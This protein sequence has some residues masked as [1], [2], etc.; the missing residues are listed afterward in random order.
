M[1]TFK[2]R[3][4]LL[5]LLGE[6]LIGSQHLA[7][8]ELVKNAYDADADQVTVT[9]NNPLDVKTAT[10]SILDNG[11]GMSLQ[12]I[13]NEWLELGTDSKEKAVKD[14][15]LTKKYKRLPLG[16]KGVGRFAAYKLGDTLTVHTKTIEEGEYKLTISL[17]EALKNKYI[18]DVHVAVEK[19]NENNEQIKTET[20][21]MVIIS[22]LLKPLDRRTVNTLHRE[23]LSIMSPF[24]YSENKNKKVNN[25]FK[26]NLLCEE[27]EEDI[28]DV[29][30]KDI[31]ESSMYRFKFIFENG[32]LQYK[33]KFAP[34]SQLQKETNIATRSIEESEQILKL[35]LKA[36]PVKEANYYENL[37]RIEGIFYVYDFDLNV[38]Q[39]YNNKQT[40]KEYTKINSGVRV[41]RGGVR[42]Y[43][44]GVIGNDWLE[45]DQERIDNPS[46]FISNRLIM[47]GIE[48]EPTTTKI[49]REKTNREGFI[50]DEEYLKFKETVRAILAVFNEQRS[51]DKEHL[52]LATDKKYKETIIDIDKPI[53][54][55]KKAISKEKL[56]K[57]IEKEINKVEKSYNQMR[58]VMLKSGLTGLNTAVTVHEIEKTLRRLKYA[59]S[60]G[61]KDLIKIE[62]NMALR[63]IDGISDLFKKDPVKRYKVSDIIKNILTL[64]ED[65]FKRHNIDFSCSLLTK[66][67]NDIEL[68][69]PKRMV[70][71]SLM[72]LIDNSIYWLSVRWYEEKDLIQKK[73]HIR[74][75]SINGYPAILILD[76][77]CRF[78]KGDWSELFRPFVTTKPMGVGMGLGLYYVKTAMDSI[79]GEIL[80]CNSD[81]YAAGK[82]MNLTG[83][84]VALIFKEN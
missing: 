22:N 68:N 40:L 66:E 64:T 69:I 59:F 38:M 21:T 26:I 6:E 60:D 3:A 19:I 30:I 44:Y 25:P 2:L 56:S 37:E 51:I 53:E 58:D 70:L 13:E 75:E 9:I 78:P 48:L 74:L 7:I 29:S 11:T 81:D 23:L 65:R 82:E 57:S 24:E 83:A 34:N 76:N 55:L 41:Y 71:N 50:E 14:N 52:R 12:T 43:N 54:D 1:R 31:I 47:G 4:R 49:L 27:F 18:D 79:N 8:F 28:K 62:L 5:K 10:V 15:V 84:A 39:Y 63:L 72:N 61:N 36:N 67:Q 45:L 32:K 77:G 35:L 80:I 33:Y 16:A 17:N 46:K 73:I 42:V 20:G